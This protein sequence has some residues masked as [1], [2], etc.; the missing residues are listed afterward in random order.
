M[1][2]CKILD[3]GLARSLA[4][5]DANLTASGTILGTPAYMAPEQASG[6]EADHRADLFSLGSVLYRM[7]TGK[8]PFP[9]A[10]TM[11]VL[12][13]LA[14]ATPPP[15]RS[16]NPKL[17]QALSDLIGKLMA[18]H[19]A[20]R[21]QSAA[22]VSAE[23]RGIVK[24]VQ[25]ERAHAARTASVY[26]SRPARS[27]LDTAEFAM[28]EPPPAD[29]AEAPSNLEPVAVPMPVRERRR[30]PVAALVGAGLLALVLLGW[31]LGA[32]AFAP[33]PSTGTVSVEFD[34]PES[35]TKRGSLVLTAP[36]GTDRYTIARGE[37]VK[38]VEAGAY[39]ARVEGAEGLTPDKREFT[40]KKGGKVTVRVTAAPAPY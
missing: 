37:R 21:P 31:W 18:K 8:M 23:V 19:P 13:A 38:R 22:E 34:A 14:N 35:R 1:R 29:P 16:L 20:L 24:G 28:L 15:A 7:A 25:A 40:V 6:E 5:E 10:N 27:T 4:G 2:R 26:Q 11:A 33:E 39:R 9:G 12:N 32:V 30:V 17:P 3:F 36:D